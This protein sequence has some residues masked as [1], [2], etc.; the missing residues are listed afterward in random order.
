MDRSSDLI[1]SNYSQGLDPENDVNEVIQLFDL[2]LDDSQLIRI[3]ANQLSDDISHWEQ[4]PWLLS[5]TDKENIA[6]T[7]GI[8]RDSR[9]NNPNTETPYV[10]NE[11]FSGLRAILSYATGQTAKPEIIPSKTDS[12]SMHIADQ[13]QSGLYQ[14]AVDHKVNDYF[15]LATK[16]LISRKRGCIKLRFDEYYGPYGDICSENVDPA[17]IVIGRNSQYG[18]DPERIYHRQKAS[19]QKLA[20]LFPDKKDEI[21]NHFGFKRGVYSQ[22]SRVV[23]YWECWF[24]YYDSQGD[25]AEGV[26]WFLPNT[27]IILGKMQNPNWNYKGSKKQQKIQNMTD[28]PIKPFI[29]LNYWNTGRSY[30]DET[31]IFDQARP[32]QDILNKRGR[33]IMENA[34]YANPRVLANGAL[35]DE[36]DA[37]KFVNKSPKTIGLLNNMAPDANI[38]NAVMV[39]QPSSLP[40]YVIEDKL[41]AR[42]SLNNMLGTPNQFRGAES[43]SKSP[44]L[45]QDILTKNTAG[46]LQDDIVEVI[47]Q[48]W[49][50]YYLYLL[51]MMNTYLDDD[52]Y[53]MTKGTDG[54]YNHIMLSSNTIDTNVR[55]SVVVDSTLPLDK[56]SQRATAV[57]LAQMGRIDDLSLFEM[58]GLP[59]PDKLVDRKIRWEIDRIG[60]LSSI[61]QQLMSQEAETDITLLMNKKTPEDRDDYDEDYLNYFNLF[62][63]SNRYFKLRAI[64]PQTA[65]GITDFLQA[66]SDKAALTEGLKS[67]LVNPAG[68]IDEPVNPP[69]PKKEIQI[70]GM[71]NPQD[72]ATEAGIQPS[73]G[74]SPPAPVGTPSPPRMSNPSQFTTHQ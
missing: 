70:R 67:S 1:P 43:Q 42:M 5:L 56:Q 6:Y 45:G 12:K 61:E 10:D 47:M 32:L 18:Q 2:E 34:D 58:L 54:E 52:Y 48:G 55:V 65:K 21:F 62:L 33:Q 30:I 46:A 14:H 36:G 26:C 13:T 11:L 7:L 41:D 39:I 50:K 40:A 63:T 23:T 74:G 22:T 20:Y 8:Q 9:V 69:M 35:W 44:T 38:N 4:E 64:D 53:V 15:R 37:K 49:A 72:S 73:P 19:I 25:A 57:Q 29:W 31:C 3:T 27:E 51:Q 66:V 17:D 24:S 68:I 16:N 59:E 71:L 28:K 60:Y